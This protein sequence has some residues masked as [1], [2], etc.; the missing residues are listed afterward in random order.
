MT[1][2]DRMHDRPWREAFHHL[3]PLLGHRNW[4]L[5]ADAAYPAQTGATEVVATGEDHL[6][7]VREVLDALRSAP[8]VRPVVYLDRELDYVTEDLAPGA[9]ATRA[10]LAET[11][12]NLGPTP[13]LHAELIERLGQVAESFR[14]LV[15][16]T[17]GVVPYSSVFV[18]LDCGY[19]SPENEA[20]LRRRMTE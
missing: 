20:E 14:V 6:A 19:W 16:K 18:E 2:E 7:V 3:L 8:H 9:D 4:I 13:V 17:T 11:L 15:L 12:R 1:P 10:G 5:I